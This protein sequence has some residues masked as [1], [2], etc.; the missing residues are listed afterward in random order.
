MKKVFVSMMVAFSLNFNA[1]AQLVVDSQGNVGIGMDTPTSTLSVKGGI[2]TN[3]VVKFEQ[4]NQSC[5]LWITS[6]PRSTPNLNLPE[7]SKSVNI[8]ARVPQDKKHIGVY[9]FVR[10]ASMNN[11]SLSS[12]GIMG[13]SLG[14][15]QSIGVYGKA[16]IWGDSTSLAV[17]VYGAVGS[18]SNTIYGSGRYAG[19]FYGPVKVT[20]KIYGT[21]F[22]PASTVAASSAS[23]IQATPF[24]K[25]MGESVC[26]KL[27]SI[28]TIQFVRKEETAKTEPSV[29][30]KNTKGIIST[31]AEEEVSE[32]EMII[33]ECSPK[34]EMIRH[35]GVDAEQLKA[36]FPELV[37]YWRKFEYDETF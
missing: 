11:T 13:K 26:E 10:S 1:G 17:G 3:N 35:Y 31:A 12:M 28:Q 16:S 23:M 27:L 18:H 9:S 5:G 15:R 21:I 25:D 37:T 19:Y 14:S 6:I 4:V 34:T 8:E 20:G 33:E 24:T 22:S 2:G 32:E 29:Q 30:A 7:L 36:V